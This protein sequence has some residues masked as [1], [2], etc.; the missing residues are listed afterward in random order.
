MGHSRDNDMGH[1][2][3]HSRGTPGGMGHSRDGIPSVLF[4]LAAWSD[5]TE[6]VLFLPFAHRPNAIG[7]EWY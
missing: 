2:R 5:H 7:L 6:P 1:S 3:G 4:Y